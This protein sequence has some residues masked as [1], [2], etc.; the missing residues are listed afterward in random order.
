M[1][2]FALVALAM[3]AEI[4]AR[5]RGGKGKRPKNDKLKK[6]LLVDYAEY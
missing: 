1:K 5:K 4:E 2:K 3:F 6:K